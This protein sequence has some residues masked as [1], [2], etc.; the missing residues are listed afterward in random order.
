MSGLASEPVRSAATPGATGFEKFRQDIATYIPSEAVALYLFALGVLIP[1]SGTPEGQVSAVKFIA[2]GVG[3]IAAIAL[4]P[5][6]FNAGTMATSEA[7]RRV[8]VLMALSAVAFC[9]YSVATPAGPWD[10]SMLG[11][12]T[13]AW[14]GVIGG[15]FTLLAPIIAGWLG[16]RP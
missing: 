8:I 5:A 12:P 13:T 16:V 1:V 2:F 15:A 4:V 11:V 14:G 3:L 6:G 9:L 10:G 7:R